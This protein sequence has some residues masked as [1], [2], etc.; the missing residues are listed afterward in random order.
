MG[1]TCVRVEYFP[2]L[3]RKEGHGI[4]VVKVEFSDNYKN[5]RSEGGVPVSN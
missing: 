5:T 4:V 1:R 3:S 2:D